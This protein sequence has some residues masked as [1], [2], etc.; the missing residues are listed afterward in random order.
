MKRSLFY[1]RIPSSCLLFHGR[2]FFLP[3]P[4]SCDI[5][6]VPH[7]GRRTACCIHGNILFATQ[8]RISCSAS[9]FYNIYT[10]LRWLEDQGI[11]PCIGRCPQPVNKRL[12]GYPECLHMLLPLVEPHGITRPCQSCDELGHLPR[13]VENELQFPHKVAQRIH[14][15]SRFRA[16]WFF[17]VCRDDPFRWRLYESTH[18]DSPRAARQP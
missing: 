10:S 12:Y 16:G 15:Y 11:L 9:A 4:E 18:L 2:F 5:P 8:R 1:L 17:R 14:G 3:Q 6:N 13:V 7:K